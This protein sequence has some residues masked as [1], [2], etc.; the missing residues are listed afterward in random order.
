M[1]V[2]I[3][4]TLLV[5]AGVA[6]FPLISQDWPMLGGTAQRNM[7]SAMMNLP[8]SW[9]VK[10]GKNIGSSGNRVGDFGGLTCVSSPPDREI[11]TFP[12]AKNLLQRAHGQAPTTIA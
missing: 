10:S 12:R 9:D 2:K 1:I 3:G 4:S 7:A 8:E 5:L 11:L 6:P